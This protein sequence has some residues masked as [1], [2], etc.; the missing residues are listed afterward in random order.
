MYYDGARFPNNWYPDLDTDALT[1]DTVQVFGPAWWIEVLEA[2]VDDVVVA[3][4][5]IFPLRGYRVYDNLGAG[6]VDYSQAR[7]ARSE[8]A[9]T[10]TSGGLSHPASWR[11]GVRA[12]NERGEEKNV[13]VAAGVTLLASGDEPPLR[14]RRPA[15]LKAT[16]RAGGTVEVTFSYDASGEPAA[17]THFHVC[18]GPGSGEVNYASPIGSV[19]RDEGDLTHYSFLTPALVHGARFR[20]AVRAAMSNDVEDDGTD[21]V[22]ATADA[23]APAQPESLGAEVAR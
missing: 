1:V 8:F 4:E 2:S 6:P 9:P 3:T 11:F 15:D 14:P 16:P 23:E 12:Y 10:W 21:Y 7:D 13:D 20:F 19:S 17:C 18:S 22:T 5:R